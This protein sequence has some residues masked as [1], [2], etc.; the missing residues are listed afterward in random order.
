VGVATKAGITKARRVRERVGLGLEGPV[1]D[2]LVLAERDLGVP[3]VI[4]ERLPGDL[5]GA[6]LPRDGKPVILLSGADPAPRMRFTLAHELGHHAFADHHQQDTHAGLVSPG[7]W[8]EVRANAFAAELLMPAPAVAEYTQPTVATVTALAERF[9]VS[10]LAAAIRL[11]TAG[12]ATP[13]QVAE[14]KLELET[15]P[16]PAPYEDSIAAAKRALPRAP[17]PNSPLARGLGEIAAA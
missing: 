4:P 3:V 17:N 6:Y 15:A 13:E 12:L 8:I 9:G 1:E 11:E 5:A 2:L 16:P 7:H 14:L 10:L